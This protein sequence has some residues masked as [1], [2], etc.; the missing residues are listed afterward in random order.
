MS[1]L[2]NCLAA[3]RIVKNET[4]MDTLIQI[5]TCSRMTLSRSNSRKA[6]KTL[7]NGI[8]NQKVSTPSKLMNCVSKIGTIIANVMGVNTVP[9]SLTDLDL[10]AKAR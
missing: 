10:I 2:E 7:T 1:S 5:M 6:S 3:Y 4:N 8:A 9:A